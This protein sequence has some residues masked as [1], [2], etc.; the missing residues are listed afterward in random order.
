M[1]SFQSKQKWVLWQ[2]YGTCLLLLWNSIYY[3][4][5][6][7]S[8]RE[9]IPPVSCTCILFLE[10]FTEREDLS[11][12]CSFS[13]FLWILWRNIK[14]FSPLWSCCFAG[15][16]QCCRGGL[17]AVYFF[18]ESCRVALSCLWAW[19]QINHLTESLN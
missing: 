18:P 4:D 17:A 7:Y 11:K 16:F 2:Q 10:V 6:L 5:G 3:S 19:L 15:I 8:M 14:H 9:I 12:D 1:N 13:P